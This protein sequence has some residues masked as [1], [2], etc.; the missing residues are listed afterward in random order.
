M[1]NQTPDRLIKTR[2]RLFLWNPLLLATISSGTACLAIWLLYCASYNRHEDRL[3]EAVEQEARLVLTLARQYNFDR[4]KTLD[5]LANVQEHYHG[6]GE[7]GE[8]LLAYRDGDRMHY[9]RHHRRDLH[10]TPPSLPIDGTLDEP[11]RLALKGRDDTVV[12]LDYSGKMVLAAH[13]PIPGLNWGGVTKIDL[14]EIRAP[15]VGAA[16]AVVCSI[17][18]LIGGGSL[19]LVFIDR[20][21]ITQLQES[22]QRYR[23]LVET[24]SDWV[25]EIDPDGR[26]TYC[27]PKVTDLLGYAPD[28][29]VGKTPLDLMPPEE[30]ERLSDGFAE[31]LAATRPFAV[32]E[33]TFS[34]QDGRL[35]VIEASGVPILDAA[36]NCLGYHGIS[37]DIT[38]RKRAEEALREEHRVLR[39]LLKSHDH[40][41][42]L[43]AYEI[44][45]GLAQPLTAAIMQLQ[46]AKDL[47]DTQPEQAREIYDAGEHLL[48]EAMSE[49]RRLIA[50]VRP[51]IL[52]E[53][54][55]VTA[56]QNLVY[57]ASVPTGPQIE[58]HCHVESERFE[59]MLENAMF[60]IVQEG[61]A[62]AC[63]HSQSDKVQVELI[64]QDNQ[65]R[66]EVRDWGVGFEPESTDSTGFGLEGIRER[67]RLLGGQAAIDSAPGRGTR[68]IVNLPLVEEPPEN[69]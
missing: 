12:G 1:K 29:T 25:W 66:I 19:V 27:S 20:P 14:A 46:A 43:I 68:V 39:K 38:E 48:T 36:G 3:I 23:S 42:Q 13:R 53:S 7:T 65:V 56:L 58:L 51:L 37:R 2:Q 41:R 5:Q 57:E 17:G 33:A 61:L 6:I 45:D 59:P 35:V 47:E 18:L 22:E 4:E 15:F 44:H 60:R 49:T 21:V 34:H 26:F 11:M 9:L 52:E 69:G 64:E 55:V 24:T 50:G 28:E 63:R 30:V 54:G 32:L 67:A 31:L 62:N 10:P 16:L 40:E 8:C